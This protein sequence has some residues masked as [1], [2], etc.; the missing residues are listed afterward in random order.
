MATIWSAL[1]YGWHH[2]Y[3]LTIEGVPVVWSESATGKTLPSGYTSE[4]AG[5]VIDDS[6]AVG[7]EVDPIGGVGKSLPLTFRLQD[8]TTARTYLKRW[9]K[10][11]RITA[12]LAGT[13]GATTLTV[14]DSTGWSAADTLYIGN[15][16]ITIG[17][18]ASGTSLTGCTRGV[19]GYRYPHPAG[20][21][22]ALVT[23]APRWWRGREVKLWAT[24]VDP[25]GSIAGS[26]IDGDAALIWRGHIERGPWRN[27]LH[28]EFDAQALDRRLAMPLGQRWS[29]VIVDAEQRFAVS[30]AA[31]VHFLFMT[32]NAAHVIVNSGS[33]KLEPF[34]ADSDGDMLTGDE[35]RA[36]IVAEFATKKITGVDAMRWQKSGFKGINDPALS[37]V[38]YRASVDFTPDANVRAYTAIWAGEMCQPNP[39]DY[40]GIVASIVAGQSDVTN[41]VTTENP[42]R[43]TSQGAMPLEYSTTVQLLEG[44]A[45][46]VPP[47]GIVRVG[48][49]VFT[50]AKRESQ[51]GLVYLSN[52]VEVTLTGA[53]GVTAGAE[54]AILAGDGGPTLP[55]ALPDVMRRM[56]ASSGEANLRNATFDTLNSG[57]GYGLDDDQVDH[58]PIGNVLGNGLLGQLKVQVAPD[59]ESFEDRFDGLLKLTQRAIVMRPDTSGKAKITCKDIGN[60]AGYT[61]TIGDADLLVTG[62]DPVVAERVDD[63]PN[64]IEVA[65]TVAGKT[66]ARYVYAD[67]PAIAAQGGRSLEL[68]L[69]IAK[70]TSAAAFLAAWSM[71]LLS[72]GQFLQVMRLRVVPWV[73][74]EI[75]DGVQLAIT[76]PAVWDWATGSPGFTG[77]GTVI[78]R[79]VR[80]ATGETTL[81]ILV[82]S[83]ANPATLCPSAVCL[84]TDHTT[85]PTRIDVPLGY[86]EHFSDAIKAA[87]AAVRVL[88]YRPGQAEGVAEGF[89]ISAAAMS[90]G[91]CR[92]TVASNVGS[93]TLTVTG[94]ADTDASHLTLPESAN[95]D[96]FQARFMH[97]AD[98]SRFV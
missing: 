42:F 23:D 97:D 91:L 39:P 9:S 60:V 10:E 29:G 87:G 90:G 13:A 2:V 40:N 33:M 45:G 98:G 27:G 69:P 44:D 24:P 70:P 35:I 41:W 55:S 79:S 76:H 7:S 6:A 88:H 30:K 78:G 83:A 47:T 19:A 73:D 11:M 84:A 5:L 31:S 4:V 92:L 63:W 61:T 77:G 62:G 57:Q 72:A 25:T 85:T 16:N 74:A 80:L 46:D 20:G 43:Q 53:A 3:W 1:Q 65:C 34:S 68:E 48:D 95:D 82:S 52:L 93:P 67:R 59:D 8:S 14:D 28:F 96:D 86:L 18:V 37:Q 36:R 12:D 56:L 51:Q 50:Y 64:R 71:Q 66:V 54:C 49:L 81:K 21:V 26:A 22:A 58:I 15:E 17:S 89:N 75:G 32:R 94:T 38:I